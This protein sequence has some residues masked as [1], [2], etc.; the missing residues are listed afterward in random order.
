MRSRLACSS[1]RLSWRMRLGAESVAG[2]FAVCLLCLSL[3]CGRLQASEG[4][5]PLSVYTEEWPP[6]SYSDN[7]RPA[8]MAV[9]VVREMLQRAGLVVEIEIIPWSRA[10]KLAIETPNVVVFAVGRTPQREELMTLIGPILSVRTE[11]YQRRGDRWKGKSAD[12]LR[13]ALLGTYR[14]AFFETLARANGFLKFSLA[15]TPDRSARMLLAGR[16]DLWVD[17]NISAPSVVQVAG[18]SPSDIEP[19]LTLDVTDMMV[20]ISRG[21]PLRTVRALEDALHAMKADGSYQRIFRHWFP[22]EIPPRHVVRVG[23]EPH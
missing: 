23:V 10:Y 3:L 12:E 17:S 21:T 16:I 9:E 6:I 19:V 1:L 13:S 18:G 22:S 8:G 11:L 4:L 20:G 2:M 15:N 14:A 7:T 5:P